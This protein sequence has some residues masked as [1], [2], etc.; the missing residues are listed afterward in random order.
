MTRPF[1]TEV[2]GR[3]VPPNKELKNLR[4]K[5][6]LTIRDVEQASR[7]IAKSKGDNQYSISNSWLTQLEHG[8][9]TPNPFAIFSLCAIYRVSFDELLRICGVNIEETQE[10][11]TIANPHLTNLLPA[12]SA[13]GS[14][15]GLVLIDT[16]SGPTTRLLTEIPS[17]PGPNNREGHVYILYGYIGS[18][19][20]TMNPLIRPGAVVEIDTRQTKV[21]STSPSPNEFEK[22]IFFVE[23][24]DSYAFGWCEM[25]GRRL[26]I[27]PHP[28]SRA[29]HREFEYPREAEIVGRVIG[30]STRC[31]R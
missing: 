15:P 10:Y 3:T 1:T 2:E 31:V 14:C 4:N 28:L 30:Y 18:N 29:Q 5:R 11:Q 23:L 7:R 16:V 17:P 8:I 12:T 20:D 21:P 22:P 9:S 24:R 19:D 25:R 26:V 6:N 27:R 13:R